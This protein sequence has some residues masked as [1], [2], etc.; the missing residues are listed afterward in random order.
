M[1]FSE[2]RGENHVEIAAGTKCRT[3]P[4]CIR[5]SPKEHYSDSHVHRENIP[6]GRLSSSL[7]ECLIE[8]SPK[9]NM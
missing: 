5:Q 3:S 8:D 1:C 4:H 6:Q 9:V 2:T 7:H